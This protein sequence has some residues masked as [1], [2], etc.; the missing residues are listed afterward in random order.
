MYKI[1]ETRKEDE[2]YFKGP[3]WVVGISKQEIEN[4][5]YTILSEKELCTYDGNLNRNRSNRKEQTHQYVWDSKFKKEFNVPYNYYP[6]GRVDVYKGKAYIN[7]NSFLNKSK[8]INDIL[9]EF[10]IDKLNYEVY[11]IDKLQQ[12]GHYDF[13]L[14]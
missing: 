14:K 3:F 10:E 6:R 9:H 1:S 8:I 13:M 11:E 7:I 12:D 5:N 4:G 2:L